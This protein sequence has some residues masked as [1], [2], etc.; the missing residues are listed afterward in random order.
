M[1][2]KKLF[3]LVLLMI[4][5]LIPIGADAE[6]LYDYDFSIIKRDYNTLPFDNYYESGEVA[7]YGPSQ[8]YV[9][10]Y[11]TLPDGTD[12]GLINPPR[13]MYLIY[14][15]T[16]QLDF[17]TTG[18]SQGNL[19]NNG[20]TMGGTCS[21]QD[22]TGNYYLNRWTVKEWVKYKDSEIYKYGLSWSIRVHNKYDWTLFVN[23]QSFFLSNELITD[24]SSDYLLSEILKQ[25]SS[26][27]SSLND[28]KSSQNSIEDGIDTTNDKLDETNQELGDINDNLTNSDVDNDNVSSTFDDF[29]SFLGDNSTIT[30]LITLPIT[31]YTSILNNVSSTCRPFNLGSMYGEELILPC[32][33]IGGYLGSTL[34]GIIDLII[35]G[36]AIYAISKKLIKVFNTFSSMKEGDVI[37]D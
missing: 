29:N 2:I 15:G 27:K 20:A 31:L 28:I 24:F 19:S 35:S 17:E 32:I 11:Y 23:I 37:D 22:Y 10:L 14:C 8:N 6:L 34:W 3:S 18:V 7:S 4:L 26:L 21:V 12:A 33:N 16:S 13:Y 36:F 1:K 30:Q 5:F 25:N 9:K